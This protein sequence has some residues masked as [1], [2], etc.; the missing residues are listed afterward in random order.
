MQRETDTCHSCGKL[1]HWATQC[2]NNND[3]VEADGKKFRRSLPCSCGA[4]SCKLFTSNTLKNPGR[5]FYRC[6]ANDKTKC[7]FFKWADEINLD[8]FI[9]VPLC[10]CG[11][12]FCRVRPNAGRI[13]FI[14]PIKKLGTY[15]GRE[16]KIWGVS[17]D[18]IQ[19]AGECS[20]TQETERSG[21]KCCNDNIWDSKS[22]ALWI[23][24]V[25]MCAL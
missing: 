10:R 15:Q 18:C 21:V 7:Q 12:N 3:F 14:C 20:R 19:G 16:E 22:Y 24:L 6:P 11:A 4:G 2:P 17:F 5:N 25:I 9:N 13:F 23:N 8:E 1:G